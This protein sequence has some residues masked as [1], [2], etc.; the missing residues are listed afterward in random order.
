MSFGFPAYSTD[1]QKFNLAPH[2][3]VEL[4]RESLHNLGWPY[5][6]P[7]PNEFVARNSVNMWSWGEKIAVEV[8]YD[9]VVK[10]KSQ[11][12]LPTQCLDWARTAGTSK[13]SSTR[14]PDWH[15]GKRPRVYPFRLTMMNLGPRWNEL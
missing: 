2:D 13:L 12:L 6:T 11:C 14:S 15:P 7:S 8:S 5:E 10:A 9:G 1:S 3:L 4:I